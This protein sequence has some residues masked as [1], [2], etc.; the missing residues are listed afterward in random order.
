M[1]EKPQNTLILD[2]QQI[3]SQI[4]QQQQNNQGEEPFI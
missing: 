3:L 1:K 4:F 2:I